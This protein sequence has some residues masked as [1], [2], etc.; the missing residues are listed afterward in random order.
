M[1]NIDLRFGKPSASD[2]FYTTI[3]NLYNAA[4]G[5]NKV[6]QGGPSSTDPLGCTGFTLL[7]PNVPCSQYFFKTRGRSSQDA[8]TSG[9]LDWNIDKND[10]AFSRIQGEQGLEAFYTDPISSVFDVDYDVSLWQGQLIE[11]HT[12]GSRAA[13]QFL[14]GGSEYDFLWKVRDP[15][16]ALAAFPTVLNFSVPGTFTGL[17]GDDWIGSYGRNSMQYQLSEDVV[18]IRGSQKLGFG[19]NFAP[20]LLACSTKHRK[21]DWTVD[22]PNRRRLLP[23]GRRSSD[24]IR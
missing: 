2:A 5:A 21:R 15:S 24:T 9:R 18:K 10:R 6:V 20:S 13:S 4:P 16:Q 14:V 7:G 17:G 11:T 19:V 12:F 1:D 3:F 8:L 22:A 23:R